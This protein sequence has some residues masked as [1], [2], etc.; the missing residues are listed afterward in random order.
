MVKH[1]QE[2]G[3][4][5]TV[6]HSDRLTKINSKQCNMDQDCS[7]THLQFLTSN[8]YFLHFPTDNLL[9]YLIKIL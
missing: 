1:I 5:F 8:S 2:A 6:N 7:S 4:N 3:D 9:R